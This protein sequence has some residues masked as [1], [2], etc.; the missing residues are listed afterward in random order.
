MLAPFLVQRQ[1]GGAAAGVGIK[2]DLGVDDLQEKI[3]L[4]LGEN[5]EFRLAGGL[6][7]ELI[8]LRVTVG[9]KSGASWY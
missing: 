3:A 5:L 9:M 1:A 8:A 2:G 7:K 6:R 4:A